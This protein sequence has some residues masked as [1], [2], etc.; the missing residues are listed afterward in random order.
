MLGTSGADM[1]LIGGDYGETAESAIRFFDAIKRYDFPRGIFGVWGNNDVEAFEEAAAL[2]DV[3]PG[4]LLI[5]RMCEMRVRGGRLMVGG[6]D[7]L[8]Y[9]EYPKK[10]LFPIANDS[11]TVL[12]AHYPKLHEAVSG[13][14]ARLM[15]SGHTHGGQFRLLGIDPY[16]IGYEH[17]HA[18]AVRGMA[19]FGATKLLTT[20]GIGVSKLPL[21]I[22]CAPQIHII[23]FK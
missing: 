17:G 15:L 23:D 3:F 4:E 14:R 6:L 10:S 9:G 13:A 19:Q 11:Y 1:L 20:N 2:E 16:M 22:G 7:E 18:D 21:R 8:G 12:M 5:N